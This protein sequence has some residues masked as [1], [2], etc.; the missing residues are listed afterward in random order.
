MKPAVLSIRIGRRTSTVGLLDLGDAKGNWSITMWNRK[1]FST[2]SGPVTADPA[3]PVHP[4]QL[5]DA[6]AASAIG[7]A[8]NQAF[9][10][11]SIG[12]PESDSM[13]IGGTAE[14][15]IRLPGAR[16]VIGP[17]ARVNADIVACDV[18]VFGAVCG[19]IDASGRVEIRLGGSLTGDLAAA[20][21]TI[22]DGVILRGSVETVTVKSKASRARKS[23]PATL[24]A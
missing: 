2:P 15:H 8:I 23:M 10:P 1:L 6:H 7:K 20:R 9:V 12:S 22:E 3:H 17:N 24:T 11:A 16:I 19:N 4:I 14:G 18:V 21:I 13:F 5:V